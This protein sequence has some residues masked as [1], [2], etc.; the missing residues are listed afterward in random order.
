MPE[1]AATPSNQAAGP[2]AP[3]TRAGLGQTP[4]WKAARVVLRCALLIVVLWVVSRELKGIDLRETREVLLEVDTSKVLLG[5]LGAAVAVSVMGLYDVASFPSTPL[6]G[7]SRRW[8]LG[9]LFY[10]WTNFLT[11]GP[12]GGPAIRLYLY[13]KRGLDPGQI[14]RGLARSY[15]G[16]VG[17][18]IAWLAAS[19]APLGEGWTGLASRGLLVLVLA[20][21][22]SLIGG[23]LLQR[24]R[25]V[26]PFVPRPRVFMTLGLI[27]ALDWGAAFAVFYFA[28]RALG[29][30]LPM[31]EQVQIMF[32]GL[33][34]GFVSMMPG[35][36][37]SADAVWLKLLTDAGLP[38]STAAAH[39]L[40]FRLTMYVAPWLASLLGLY[41]Q[42][43]GRTD[44][45]MRWQRR[46]LAGAIGLNALWLLA[47]TATPAVRERLRMLDRMV[48]VDAVELSHAVA[49]VAAVLM[50]FLIR[51]ILRGY[52]AAFT[53]T[54]TLLAVSAAAHTIKGGDFEESLV[55][56]GM[57]T[58]L[59]GAHRAFRRR[60]RIPVGWELTAAAGLGSLAFFVLL[61]F[62]TFQNERWRPELFTRVALHAESSRVVRGAALVGAVGL[63]FLVR[64]AMLPRGTREHAT[65]AELDRAARFIATHAER[66]AALNVAAGDKGV[67]FW[68]PDGEG[69]PERGGVVYQRRLG[70]IVVFSDPVVADRDIDAMLED[71]HAFAQDQ[72]AE[73]VFYQITARFMSTCTTSATR[74]SSWA[75][76]RW[77]PSR[78][79]RS[80]AGRRTS[81][82]RQSGAWSRRG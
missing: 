79:S 68:T 16:M 73:L 21:S 40:L 30:D 72:D 51:G 74:S 44:A 48:P 64:Q 47:S 65:E 10:S 58:L 19:F 67:W 29:V 26:G 60:G 61:G 2:D 22:L 32:A 52:R 4:A 18:L 59:L 77:C 50:I 5:L 38:S 27:G 3:G 33:A 31:S 8:F 57:L 56:L 81:T 43:A 69:S 42:F 23:Q 34:V 82:E 63:V 76:R 12:I 80:G 15:A 7:R 13:R 9:M 71:L 53:V 36:L 45:L 28:G 1:T 6:L 78:S 20:P 37:G 70:K 25:P 35:G 17:G 49:V 24:I 11:L 54:G 14:V 66:A 55:S 62:A 39:I 41:V 75:K 46:V